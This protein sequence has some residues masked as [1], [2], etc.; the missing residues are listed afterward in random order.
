MSEK[1]IRGISVVVEDV[2]AAGEVLAALGMRPV[3]TGKENSSGWMA[4]RHFIALVPSSAVVAGAPKRAIYASGIDRDFCAA[5]ISFL[6]WPSK[7][8]EAVVADAGDIAGIDHVIAMVDSIEQGRSD[9]AGQGMDKD[10]E[11]IREFPALTTR[12]QMFRIGAGYVEFNEPLSD[13]PT[14]WGNA[15]GIVGLVWQCNDLERF[16]ASHSKANLSRL[17]PVQARKPGQELETLG[18]VCMV[19]TRALGDFQL[20][21]FQPQLR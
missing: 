19:K 21:C 20:Y 14:A 3:S 7:E 11:A 13:A 4:G 5:G 16:H 12:A 15:R 2:A 10:A 8:P 18:T 9:L 6:P 1:S 17:S